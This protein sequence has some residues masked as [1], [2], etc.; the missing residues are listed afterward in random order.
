[1]IFDHDG[2]VV[3]VGPEGTRADLP[4]RRLGRARSGGDLAVT[5]ARW[6]RPPWR[7]KICTRPTSPRSASPISARPPWSGTGT[8]ENPCTTRSSGR[9]PAPTNCARNSPAT[10]VRAAT[11]AHRAAAVHLLLRPEGP[12]DPRQRRR[13][14]RARRGRRAL[15]RHDGQL[16]A[17]EPHRRR[18]GGARDRRHQRVPHHA[19]GS[20]TLDWDEQICADSG[21]PM[22]MLPRDPQLLGGVRRRS[23]SAA[24]L[25]GVPDRGHPRRPAGR[26]VRAG[27]PVAPGEAKNTYGTGNF[28][29]LNTGTT[30]VLSEHGLLT[31]VCYQIGDAPAVY[32]LEGSVAVTGS[33]VQWLRDNLGII[34]SAKEIEDAG[35]SRRRQRRRLLRAGVLRA[36]RAAL[37]TRRPRGD[38]RAH[39]VRQQG[40]PR[41]GRAGGHRV[42]DP[43]GDRGDARRFRRR[44]RPRSRWTAAWSSTRP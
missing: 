8:P 24:S 2:P 42:S 39:P 33:L 25:A 23:A 13:C 21:I 4:A 14:P 22:S 17:V 6:W 3:S 5:P 36:V 43:R 35:A 11:A 38:R 26:H 29:L 32:A 37:A 27:L 15:L 28:L 1:M 9:T 18:D 12:L 31:T 41:A 44:A 34:S 30:P 19:D 40:A 7:K 16:D 20:R 10:R